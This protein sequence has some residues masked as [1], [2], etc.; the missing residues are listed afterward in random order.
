MKIFVCT[1]PRGSVAVVSGFNRGHAVKILGK[2]L[3][4]EAEAP[5]CSPVDQWAVAEFDPEANGRK[6]N[7]LI[8]KRW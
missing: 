1:S 5:A 4:E 6:G 8:L 7:L 2:K 3:K